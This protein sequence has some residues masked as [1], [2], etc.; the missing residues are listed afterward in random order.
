MPEPVTF[1]NVFEIAPENVDAFVADWRRRAALMATKPGC[2]EFTLHR[3]LNEETGN[4]TP[5]QVVNVARWES[6]DHWRAAV[7][8]PEFRAMRSA[9]TGFAA[10]HPALYRPVITKETVA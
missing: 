5:F 4:T 2:L 1:I 7:A 10:A 3:A 8:D 6:A 9:A